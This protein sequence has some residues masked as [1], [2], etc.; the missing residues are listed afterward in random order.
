M[1]QRTI[2]WQRARLGK[3]TGSR[4]A[5]LMTKSRT[6][7][8]TFGAT[9]MSYIRKVAAQRMLNPM[10]I[11][12][13][14]LFGDYL[15]LTTA[16]SKVMRW[17]TEQE[18]EAKRLYINVTKNKVIDVASVEMNEMPYFSASPDGVVVEQTH[19]GTLGVLEIKCSLDERFVEFCQVED[20]ESL[21]A[22]EPKYYW[23]VM[24]EMA[25]TGYGF[26]DFVVYNP[27]MRHPLHVARITRDEAAIA[28][29]LERVKLANE[30]VES[31][32]A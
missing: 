20:G 25:V 30:V 27:W 24:S 1:E 14:E 8:E 21:K 4:V 12:D 18:D 17:G 2:E 19:N 9:A 23:Q 11:E 13:D 16:T 28:E 32:I 3:F 29:L 15:D 26:C 5:D 22:A 6:K 7:G 31:L 10:L